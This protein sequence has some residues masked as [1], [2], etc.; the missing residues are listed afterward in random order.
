LEEMTVEEKRKNYRRVW[1]ISDKVRTRS[2]RHWRGG[3][4]FAGLQASGMDERKGERKRGVLRETEEM[5]RRER[6]KGF[7]FF[8]Y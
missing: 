8:L 3:N 2:L 5:V 7:E 4:D 1:G 6:E